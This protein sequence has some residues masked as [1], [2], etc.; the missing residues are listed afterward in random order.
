MSAMSIYLTFIEQDVA[1]AIALIFAITEV[2]SEENHVKDHTRR[3]T[4]SKKERS[5]CT[6][7]STPL[8]YT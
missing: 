5:T 7:W 3:N 8:R 1:K 2:G 6:S 4:R